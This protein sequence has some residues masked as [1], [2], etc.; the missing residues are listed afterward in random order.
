MAPPAREPERLAFDVVVRGGGASEV[1]A[2]D[3][4]GLV[5]A[6]NA[7]VEFDTDG[8]HTL[9]KPYGG[10]SLPQAEGAYA[11][12]Y[13]VRV[14]G[15]HWP[16]SV[17]MADYVPR[18]QCGSGGYVPP[19]L[20]LVG[21]AHH[22]WK[23]RAFGS[24]S[25]DI[26]ASS[27]WFP[28]TSIAVTVSTPYMGF[29]SQGISLQAIGKAPERAVPRASAAPA[30]TTTPGH[31][32]WERVKCETRL[33]SAA[34]ISGLASGEV[35]LLGT[36]CNTAAAA[37]EWW[38]ADATE[39]FTVMPPA[40][41]GIMNLPIVDPQT[42]WPVLAGE[43]GSILARSAREV[44]V[45]GSRAGFAYLARFDGQDWR[46]LEAPMRSAITS[47]DGVPGG[48]VWLTT[49][50]GELWRKPDGG[51]WARVD[52][53]ARKARKVRV[54]SLTDVWIVSDDGILRS[55]PA[56]SP[57]T[58]PPLDAEHP[59]KD[60]ARDPA[61]P[62]CPSI[63]VA[64][65]TLDPADAQPNRDFPKT[66]AILRGHPE[67]ATSRFVV[68]NTA[69]FGALVDTM[70]AARHVVDVFHAGRPNTVPN[71]LCETPIV[72]RD[73][74]FEWKGDEVVQAPDP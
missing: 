67:L 73:L 50:D 18:G 23:K 1:V 59:E 22:H 34:S 49:L 56:A 24:E 26:E 45:G 40:P 15:G 8:S 74:R 16:D 53:G 11:S 44:Y 9:W 51:D 27:R 55:L 4:G 30:N 3:G 64:L 36:V 35:F 41:K 62:A 2:G 31:D 5:L 47:M 20:G 71:L 58:L 68:T 19:E 14:A 46:V 57:A 21:W 39:H 7:M 63:F 38:G 6:R 12:G 60:W 72:E 17:F 13:T 37:V 25:G 48:S 61:T 28:G 42:H 33:G 52:L 54:G 10:E 65:Y 43:A 32:E 66:R 70:D 69:T 29:V